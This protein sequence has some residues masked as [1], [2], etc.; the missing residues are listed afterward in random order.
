VEKPDYNPTEDLDAFFRTKNCGFERRDLT[1][2]EG[3]AEWAKHSYLCVQ[4]GKAP[5]VV[6]VFDFG[7]RIESQL[8]RQFL[9]GNCPKAKEEW[10]C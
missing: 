7:Q 6:F 10:D 5:P 2:W 3:I 1:S 8:M 4:A 9:A